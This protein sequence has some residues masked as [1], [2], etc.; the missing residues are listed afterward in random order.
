[1]DRSAESPQS[2]VYGWLAFFLKAALHAR[3]TGKRER[4]RESFAWLEP[5]LSFSLVL[6]LSFLKKSQ[7]VGAERQNKLD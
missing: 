6:V 5:S 3:S 7:T 2:D 4:E 1:M